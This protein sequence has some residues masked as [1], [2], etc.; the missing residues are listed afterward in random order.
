M[1]GGGKEEGG[2]GR[3]GGRE[4]EMGREDGW[5]DLLTRLSGLGPP[6]PLRSAR[7]WEVVNGEDWFFGSIFAGARVARGRGSEGMVFRRGIWKA[8]ARE[9]KKD[10]CDIL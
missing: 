8:C 9:R 3:L 2:E 7:G 10:E 6:L 4:G 1:R 5:V